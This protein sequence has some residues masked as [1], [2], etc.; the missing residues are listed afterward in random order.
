MERTAGA[1]EEVF[2][3]WQKALSN[4][5]SRL[6]DKRRRLIG[7]RLKDGYS[8][9]DLQLAVMGC[10]ASDWHN[11]DN[12]RHQR[13]VGIELIC[14]D[15]EHVDRFI[16]IAERAASREIARAAQR[17]DDRPPAPLAKPEEVRAKIKALRERYFPGMADAESNRHL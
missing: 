3:F 13:Y 16:E 1:V 8:V 5:R 4:G 11:G 7:A 10:R 9:E 6:D 17:K 15:A 12:D 14:R 2:D